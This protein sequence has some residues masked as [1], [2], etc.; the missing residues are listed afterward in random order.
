MHYKNGRPAQNGDKVIYQ[1]YDGV[2]IS[3]VLY[4]AVA[5]NNDC[6]GRIAV[7]SANDPMP[8]LKEVLHADD[9]KAV[10]VS[11]PDSSAP[12][13]PASGSDASGVVDSG[14]AVSDSAQA[15]QASNPSL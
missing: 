4:D 15:Q 7:I 1:R 8:D 5:G 2:L 3:G 14:T 12:K 13:A 10:L 6:N 11:V 9:V